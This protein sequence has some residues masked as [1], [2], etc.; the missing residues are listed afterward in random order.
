MGL[1]IAKVHK[2]AIAHVLRHEPAEART[3]S[4]ES[5]VTGAGLQRGHDH[6]PE[7]R[8]GGVGKSLGFSDRQVAHTRGVYI[9]ERLELAPCRVGRGLAVVES[10]IERGLQ[11]CQNTVGAQAAATDGLHIVAVM[12]ALR[13]AHLGAHARGHLGEV[14]EP[15]PQHVRRQRR[16]LNVAKRRVNEGFG[17]VTRVT[18]RPTF[19]FEVIEVVLD[20]GLNGQ[21]PR[22]F[23]SDMH[24]PDHVLARLRLSLTE[25]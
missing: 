19:A 5:S 4:A 25:V 18:H 6:R 16:D 10:L 9:L 13:R 21:R 3:V 15:L 17:A 8:V 7:F 12:G 22:D 23:G 1:R 20:G 24:T 2:H 11:D 14:A